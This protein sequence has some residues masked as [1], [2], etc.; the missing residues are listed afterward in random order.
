M[1]VLR[2]MERRAAPETELRAFF[3]MAVIGS[4]GRVAAQKRCRLAWWNIGVCLTPPGSKRRDLSHL[5]S[6]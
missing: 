4:E 1:H 3:R 2:T 5:Y 6:Q